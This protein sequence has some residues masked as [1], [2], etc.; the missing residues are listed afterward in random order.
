MEK[1]KP[2]KKY[3]SGTVTLTVWNNTSDKGEWKTF[4][5]DRN[6]KDQNDEWKK[7]NSYRKRDL[8]DIV[9]CVEKAYRDETLK[10]EE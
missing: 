5:I 6:Y 1:T 9:T 2:T 8:I 4:Q 10:V 7:T 3:R